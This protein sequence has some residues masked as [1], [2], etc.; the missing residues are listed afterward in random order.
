MLL[1]FTFPHL[2]ILISRGPNFLLSLRLTTN[3]EDLAVIL[4]RPIKIA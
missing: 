2:R 3:W 1:N 4:S